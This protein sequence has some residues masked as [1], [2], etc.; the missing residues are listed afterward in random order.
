MPAVLSDAPSPTVASPAAPAATGQVTNPAMP[1]KTFLFA[2]WEGGG[3]TPPM[4][5]LVRRLL[6]RGHSVR[7][8][9]DPCSRTE[10]ETAGAGF[11]AWT[12]LIS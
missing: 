1:G 12:R 10:I 11:A 6:A 4:L 8:L 7:V 2:H 3:N 9:S 5:A